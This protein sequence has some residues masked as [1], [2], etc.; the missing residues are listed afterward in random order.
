MA[1]GSK[2][3][4]VPALVSSSK[5]D[6]PCQRSTSFLASAAGARLTIAR[7]ATRAE[8]RRFIGDGSSRL[9]RGHLDHNDRLLQRASSRIA[10][11]IPVTFP[12]IV[13]ESQHQ[14]RNTWAEI[15]TQIRHASFGVFPDI[16][17]VSCFGF[18]V[19]VRGWM[20]WTNPFRP[21]YPPPT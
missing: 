9:I 8:R 20:H 19:S 11:C 17:S 13:Q 18:R 1:W 7:V 6:W 2:T 16:V 5:N 15:P 12:A 10:F 14:N 3:T 21:L 4:R